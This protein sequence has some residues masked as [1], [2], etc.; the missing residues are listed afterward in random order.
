MRRWCR[1]VGEGKGTKERERVVGKAAEDECLFIPGEGLGWQMRVGSNAIPDA[2]GGEAVTCS[3]EN[4]WHVA[5]PFHILHV[6]HS[7]P[8][9][10]IAGSSDALYWKART[11]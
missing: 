10:T 6:F 4:F 1:K 9:I 2:A 11:L 5:F 7:S 8:R 3:S